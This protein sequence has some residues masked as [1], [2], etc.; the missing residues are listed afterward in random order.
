MSDGVDKIR[1]SVNK[2]VLVSDHVPGR[3]PVPNVRMDRFS[4]QNRPEALGVIG[5]QAREK[6]EFIHAFEIESE[7]AFATVDFERIMVLSSRCK[8]GRLKGTNGL[9]G[10]LN[11]HQ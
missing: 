7:R 4:N 9:G 2:C 11:H 1:D 10:E 3:P 6:L 8:S 5:I